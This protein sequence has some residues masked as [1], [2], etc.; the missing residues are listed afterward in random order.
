VGMLGFVLGWTVL[1]ALVIGTIAGG[2][3]AAAYLLG[4]KTRKATIAYG[5]YLAIGGIVAILAFNP[6][7]FF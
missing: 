2:I 5:P 3:A 6:P 1:R 4:S 7:E